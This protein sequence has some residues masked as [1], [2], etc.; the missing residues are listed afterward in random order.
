MRRCSNP[1]CK[2]EI[3]ECNGTVKAGDFSEAQR[4]ERQWENVREMCPLCATFVNLLT[5]KGADRQT[6]SMV[7]GWSP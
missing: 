2:R 1:I 5:E 7:F 4:G 6:L 3:L